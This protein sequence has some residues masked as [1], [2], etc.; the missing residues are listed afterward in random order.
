[1]KLSAKI[2]ELDSP[3]GNLVGFASLVI[4]DKIE[5]SGFRIIQRNDGSGLFISAPSTGREVDG[6]I[7]YFDDVRFLD[8]D[9]NR[10]ATR[11]DVQK[12]ILDTLEWERKNSD[13]TTA[14]ESQ[15]NTFTRKRSK[16]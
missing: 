11:E 4:D 5:I 2:R 3:K 1:M 10:S 15:Q 8:W 7:K 12:V 13:R 9:D 14:A 6:E 16:W